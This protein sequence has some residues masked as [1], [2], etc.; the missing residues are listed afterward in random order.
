MLSEAW[1]LTSI[2]QGKNKKVK[3]TRQKKV[4][5]NAYTDWTLPVFRGRFHDKAE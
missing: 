2:S 5:A 4:I 1:N 3:C